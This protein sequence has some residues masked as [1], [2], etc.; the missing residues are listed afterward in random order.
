MPC[1]CCVPK[2]RR[3]KRSKRSRRPAR[4]KAGSSPTVRRWNT[5]C[6]LSKSRIGQVRGHL[7]K[8]NGQ[9]DNLFSANNHMASAYAILNEGIKVA[10]K[11]NQEVRAK[12]VPPSDQTEEDMITKMKREQQK[13]DV[14]DHIGR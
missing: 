7:R 13:M 2:G 4:K 14:E 5:K 11:E 8:M 10:E 12:L 9:V 3:W 1:T 6:L